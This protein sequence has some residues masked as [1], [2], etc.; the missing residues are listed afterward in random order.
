MKSALNTLAFQANASTTFN[1][2]MFQ[3]DGAP[4]FVAADVC[5]VLG[6]NLEGGTTTHLKK[7]DVDER[8]PVPKDLVLGSG[9]GMAQAVLV[10]E[11]GLYKLI[12]KSEKPAAKAF[13]RWVRHEVLPSI[14]KTGGYLLN[15]EA[16][17]TAHADDRLAMPLPE[18]FAQAMAQVLEQ[19]AEATRKMLE[20]VLARFAPAAPKDTREWSGGAN[21]YRR[22]L[23]Q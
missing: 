6:L 10:S 2:R 5:R 14:R 16:R 3:I 12:T 20:E 9:R 11:P 22:A 8:R 17:E 13:D 23:P 15:E 4:W 18:L 21:G 19:N 1:V 7:L